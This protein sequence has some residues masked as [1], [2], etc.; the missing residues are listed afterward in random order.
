M[1]ELV[2]I[3]T[4][5]MLVIGCRSKVATAPNPIS[6]ERS[7]LPITRS[8]VSAVTPVA[9]VA[10]DW[11]RSPSTNTASYRVY[12]GVSPR[13]YTN[14]MAVG[15]NL[16]AR[17][18]NLTVGSTYF[19]SA[20]ASTSSGLESTYSNEDIW[21]ATATAIELIV[22]GQHSDNSVGPYTSYPTPIYRGPPINMQFFRTVANVQT[23]VP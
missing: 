15:T 17:I 12:W 5:L 3:L 16:T 10:L 7:V 9:S 20:T 21:T 13:N 19:F 18:S 2:A 11:D 1:K 6:I 22:W 14:S 8:A 4:A 23:N